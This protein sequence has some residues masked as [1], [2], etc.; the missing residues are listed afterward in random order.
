MDTVPRKPSE[1]DVSRALKHAKE[2][3]DPNSI[4]YQMGQVLLYLNDRCKHLEEIHTHAKRY[5]RS[6]L[7]ESEHT[8]LKRAIDMMRRYDELST[9]ANKTNFGLE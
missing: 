4:D 5:L 2:A 1:E 7:P 8:Q 6:G 3:S 9:H